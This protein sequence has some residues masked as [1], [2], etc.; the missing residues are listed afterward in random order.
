MI[1]K[2]LFDAGR[3]TWRATEVK[4]I[5]RSTR[6]KMLSSQEKGNQWILRGEKPKLYAALS[7][8]CDVKKFNNSD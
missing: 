8:V 5:G 6:Q 1:Y 7:F 4:Y 3:K 2:S